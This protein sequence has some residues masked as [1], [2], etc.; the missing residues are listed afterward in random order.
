MIIRFYQQNASKIL[1]CYSNKNCSKRIFP[2]CSAIFWQKFDIFVVLSFLGTKLKTFVQ[3]TKSA[4]FWALRV[5]PFWPILCFSCSHHSFRNI[6]CSILRSTLL[7]FLWC[8]E[9]SISEPK[10]FHFI[11][12]WVHHSALSSGNCFSTEIK[13]GF[14][15]FQI[16]H[17]P[18]TFVSGF[19]LCITKMFIR[20]F[21]NY[22]GRWIG[23]CY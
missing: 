6:F 18:Q 5:L 20:R 3:N 11:K 8:S 19:I 16:V 2:Q 21:L 10:V 15:K 9:F 22:F 23:G 17:R 4:F 13:S 1:A 14:C 7:S 12:L